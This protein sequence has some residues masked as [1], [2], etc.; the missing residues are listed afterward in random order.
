[1]IRT[2]A[3]AFLFPLVTISV[4]AAQ[5]GGT[6]PVRH[7]LMPVPRSVAFQT[8][9][10]AVQSSFTVAVTK[11]SDA[12][13]IAG[14]DRALRRLERRTGLEFPRALATD[15]DAATLLIACDGPGSKVPSVDENESYTLAVDAK[16]A[17]LKAAT[18]VGVLRGLET[19]LQLVDGDRAGYFLPAVTVDDAPRFPWRGLLI[20]VCRHWMPIE[21]IKRNLDGMAAVKLNV[22]HL[23]LTE[24]QGFRIESK[25]FPKLH[26][27][28]SDGNFF[29][30]DQ[31]RE[32]VAYAAERG[33]RVVPEFDMPGHVTSWLV[34]HPELASAPGPY[35]I[36]RNWGVFDA[37]LDPTRESVY[38]FL[39]VF[40]R[41][42]AGLFPDAYM[43]IGGDE[44]N[45]KHWNANAAIT[46]FMGKHKLADA[47]ALQAYFNQ[48]LTRILK[49][50]NKRMVGWDE[51]LHSDL[52]K[53][54]VVQ[55]W[56]GQ[57]S[58]AD[59]ARKGYSGILSS[60]YY[61]DLSYKTADH[62]LVDPL[63]PT[64]T[65]T[66]EEAT[67]V[68]GGE[69]CMWAEWITPE[70]IDS[71]IWPRTAAIA[72]RFWSP[73][74]V[75]DVNDM[76]RRLAA[77]SIQLE[78]LGL[79]HESM[80]PVMLRRLS[81]SHS[82]VSLSVLASVVEPVKGYRR[83]RGKATTQFAPLTRLVDAARP[84]SMVALM[85]RLGVNE[86][87]SDAPRF[88][89]QKQELAGAFQQFRDIR[90]AIDRLIDEAP[91]LQEVAPLA[92]DLSG[93]GAL[94]IEAL[95]Y[96]ASGIAPAAD[97][98]EA[99]LS[100]IDRAAAP[101]ADVELAIILPMRKLIVAAAELGQLAELGPRAWA[102]HVDTLAAP[103]PPVKK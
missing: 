16:Q 75:R 9:R 6:P 66:S 1:M 59:S 3:L 35:A 72:E 12:R 84:D 45:G 21:V 38:K 92:E 71:R 70:T 49:K 101:R 36:G 74:T 50:Y 58:L 20:D 85:L 94:G 13:L 54:A 64:V 95:S 46:A 5:E 88:R 87:V 33:I 100:R 7:T 86:L 2:L 30:Q 103:P 48:R 43:H 80:A 40:Y 47:N 17:V 55:S 61:I 22:L 10:L 27:M 102:A 83:G 28:G 68:L 26:Q 81:G 98:R 99:A 52:P 76:Y 53:D 32:I 23:H 93:L 89:V 8:G 62:Y 34:G 19:M 82:I 39:D 90:P 14:I 18:T 51:I 78:D 15:A 25:K 29:T 44:N 63:P 4:A 65:L 69:A 11:T 41:E 79:R 60:G 96:L 37:A 42:M 91:V 31:I 73:G 56:R 57:A 24:D 77:M 67:R 97:W